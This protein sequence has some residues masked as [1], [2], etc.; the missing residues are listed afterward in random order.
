VKAQTVREKSM[1]AY[2]PDL[3]KFGWI[4]IRLDIVRVMKRL[5]AALGVIAALALLVF[6][7][8]GEAPSA[9]HLRPEP[10]KAPDSHPA[11]A[12]NSTI[13]QPSDAVRIEHQLIQVAPKASTVP[14]AR[15][16][17]RSTSVGR[18]MRTSGSHAFVARARRALMGDGRYRPEPFPRPADR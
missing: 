14:S 4:G 1:S 3:Q 13:A 5:T 8:P 10:A 9:Q 7:R 12:S 16:S 15:P 2:C 18:A 11:G 17:D 6:P